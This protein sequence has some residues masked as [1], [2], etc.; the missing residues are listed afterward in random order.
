MYT[1]QAKKQV[2]MD[3][4]DLRGRKEGNYKTNKVAVWSAVEWCGAEES[5]LCNIEW[6][7]ALLSSAIASAF[8]LLIAI[9]S[10]IFTKGVRLFAGD[11]LKYTAIL[12]RN[13]SVV[14]VDA[15]A[16]SCCHPETNCMFRLCF[17]YLFWRFYP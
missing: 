3:W 15:T 6:P 9:N 12:H 17:I 14:W 16:S 8:L 1:D 11:R 2:G 4:K 13:D 10:Y 5:H 7:I